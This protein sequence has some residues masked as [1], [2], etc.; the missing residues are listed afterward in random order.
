MSSSR[1]V[2]LRPHWI[3]AHAMVL[4]VVVTFPL[5]GLWQLDRWDHEKALQ[6]RIEARIDGPTVALAEVLSRG[7]SPGALDDLEYQP[8][9]ATGT[10]VA[11]EEVAHRNR[12][13]DGRGGFDWLTPLRLAD[14]TAVLVRRGFVPPTRVSGV[15]PTVAPPPSGDVA[16]TGWLEHSGR[17]PSGF[18]AGL[19]PR[20]PATGTLDTVFHADVAR[21]DAQTSSDLLPM[22]LHLTEQRPPQAGALPVVQPAPEVDL[23]QN[24][25]YAVQW[26]VF[27]AIAAIGYVVVLRRR[28][29][30]RVDDDA[31]ADTHAV[32]RG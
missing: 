25:S 15:D 10:Y 24:L 13:L 31:A 29:G 26:F 8:V 1:L 2:L 3:V 18:A 23:D 7:L 16:V 5:L 19:A 20:D 30:T 14:G 28:W 27:A 4:A 17:Q 6:A 32:E 11:D 12:D 21:I 9:T 22:V